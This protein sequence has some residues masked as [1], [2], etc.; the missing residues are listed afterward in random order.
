MAQKKLH[1]TAM[2]G[3]GADY[4]RTY[5]HLAVTPDVSLKDLLTPAFWGFHT[6]KF[7]LADLI[8]VVCLDTGLDVQLRVVETGV[9]FV[10][11]RLLRGD[12]VSVMESEEP[13]ADA[14]PVEVPGYKITHSPRTR[15]R[16]MLSDG[17]AEVARNLQSRDEA[18]KVA[19]EHSEKSMAA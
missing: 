2:R 7:R 4:L 8:D 9:G 14:D 11:M 17:M 6:D 12:A 16:V 1:A 18:V 13:K 3:N 15:W 19:L 10:R 5:H